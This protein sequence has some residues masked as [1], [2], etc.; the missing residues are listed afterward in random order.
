MDANYSAAVMP[1]GTVRWWG[2]ATLWGAGEHPPDGVF[3][4]KIALG[5]RHA[6]GLDVNGAAHCWGEDLEQDPWPDPPAGVWAQI[7]GFNEATC[8]ID[9]AGTLSAGGGSR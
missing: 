8:V 4:T 3:F 1:D 6:C 9:A 7:E 5:R 2:D